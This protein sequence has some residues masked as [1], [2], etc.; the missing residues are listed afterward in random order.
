VADA[1]T[2]APDLG[3]VFAQNIVPPEF[4]DASAVF[5]AAAMDPASFAAGGASPPTVPGL[6]D[7]LASSL[8]QNTATAAPTGGS[9]GSSSGSPLG[10][11][12]SSTPL[13]GVGA[14][15]GIIGSIMGA[16]GATDYLIRGGLILLGIVLIG[17]GVMMFRPVQQVAVK[18]AELAS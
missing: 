6:S 3:G 5:G 14:S 7:P 15:P 11:A 4:S 12:F 9:G 2:T 13:P 17:V 1:T 8:A 10:D 16:T 18:G